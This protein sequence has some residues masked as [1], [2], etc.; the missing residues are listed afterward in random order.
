LS[1][2]EYREKPPQEEE[3]QSPSVSPNRKDNNLQKELQHPELLSKLYVLNADNLERIVPN[4]G[5]YVLDNDYFCGSMN[6]MI[7][8]PDV[9]D[10]SGSVK[11]P[12]GSTA[13][14]V[15]DYFRDKKRQ[16]EFQFQV[17]M[18]KLPPGPLYLGCELDAP[19][20]LGMIQRAFVSTILGV[21]GKMNPGL[22]YSFGM[23]ESGYAPKQ[24]AVKEG[25]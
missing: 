21:V 2:R 13:A 14:Q 12:L 11:L 23:D 24:S 25:R 5:P 7:R 8:T 6:L 17:K 18:K 1:L 19:L 15:S 4:S 16:F 9:D 22:H 20:K 3:K 10:P